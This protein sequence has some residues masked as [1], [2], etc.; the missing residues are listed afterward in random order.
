LRRQ[1]ASRLL[2]AGSSRNT[3]LDPLSLPLRIA[4]DESGAQAPVGAIE[5]HSDRVIFLRPLAG[6]TMTLTLPLRCFLGVSMRMQGPTASHGG[7]AALVLEHSDAQ[8]SV[9]LHRGADLRDVAWQWR[10]WASVLDLPLLVAENDGSLR[11]LLPRLDGIQ[12][13]RTLSRRRC[14]SLLKAR[15]GVQRLRR[16]TGSPASTKVHRDER[17]IIARN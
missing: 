5:L 11:E 1:A 13:G 3:R 17:E 10:C 16:R 9:T 15:R 12:M 6:I 4:A 2:P 7:N 8:L 14:R